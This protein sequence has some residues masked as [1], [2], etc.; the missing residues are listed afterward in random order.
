VIEAVGVARTHRL[1]GVDMAAWR[2][3]TLTPQA[4]DSVAVTGPG[5]STL[6]H[7]LGALDRPTSETVRIDGQ[8]ACRLSDGAL[9]QLRTRTGLVLSVVSAA[10]PDVSRG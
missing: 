7:V 1:E 6:R 3:I 10:V 9:A 4:G 5:K 2:R 8:D